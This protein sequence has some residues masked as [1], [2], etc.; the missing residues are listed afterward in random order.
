[1]TQYEIA[2]MGTFVVDDDTGGDAHEL[3]NKYI[4]M[5]GFVNRG[6]Y[7]VGDVTPSLPEEEVIT[8]ANVE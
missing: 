1:M 3:A 8:N 4:E 7:I 6:S 5:V 2:F